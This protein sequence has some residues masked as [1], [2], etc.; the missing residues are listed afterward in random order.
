MYVFLSN[1]SLLDISYTSNIVPKLL[2]ILLTQHKIISFTGCMIQVYFFMTFV[3][4]E[5]FLLAVMAYDRF[6]A[7]SNPLHYSLIMNS[8]QCTLFVTAVWIIGLLDSVAHTI[9][10]SNLCFCSSHDIDHF[11]CDLTPLLK[12]TC[13]DTSSVEILTY[14]NGTLLWLTT[15][16][17]TLV[18][19]VFIICT[20]L[21]IQSSGGRHKAFST[22]ASHLICVIIFYGTLSCLYMRPTSTYSLKQDKFYA[23]LYIIL[24]P[25]LNPFIYTLKNKDITNALKK[26]EKKIFFAFENH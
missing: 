13:S 8:K 21:K 25:L 24:I 2:D 14:I 15:F 18:S 23:L 12:L 26:L 3:C 4:T 19:Y 5:F 11:F 20:I 16:A 1:L 17:P 9:F 22:C 10:I 6:V 7:I